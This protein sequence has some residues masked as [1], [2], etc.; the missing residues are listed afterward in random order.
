MYDKWISFLSVYIA[1]VHH[2]MTRQTCC[3]P[4]YFD[5]E[6]I[7]ISCRLLLKHFCLNDSSVVYCH[8]ISHD[9]QVQFWSSKLYYVCYEHVQTLKCMNWYQDLLPKNSFQAR[10]FRLV[11]SFTAIC[12]QSPLVIVSVLE[13]LLTIF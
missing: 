10:V 11:D 6:L 7:W 8:E 3:W 9:L 13:L 12:F 2:Y 1:H 4:K 5:T